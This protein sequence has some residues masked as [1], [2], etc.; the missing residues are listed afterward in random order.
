[1]II[2]IALLHNH[3]ICTLFSVI[4]LKTGLCPLAQ[5]LCKS[6]CPVALRR[7]LWCRALAVDPT[8]PEVKLMTMVGGKRA[9][10]ILLGGEEE[11][12]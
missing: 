3:M 11:R 8:L 12:E 2:Y 10:I 7:E 4:V 9:V 6:G 1:M 5:Q